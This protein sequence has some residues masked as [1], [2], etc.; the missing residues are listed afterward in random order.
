MQCDTE[1]VTHLEEAFSKPSDGEQVSVDRDLFHL[2]ALQVVDPLEFKEVK[3]LAVEIL[4][5]LPPPSVT[6]FVFAQLLTFLREEAPMLAATSFT[7]SLYE[8][9]LQ[10]LQLPG[11][12]GIIT[13]KLMVYYLNRVI[14]EDLG[15]FKDKSQ[16]PFIV[17]V[18][19]QVLS[20]PSN[21]MIGGDKSERNLLADLQMG[22]MDCVALLILRKLGD[23]TVE[24]SKKTQTTGSLL[25]VL[26]D[27]IIFDNVVSQIDDDEEV[28]KKSSELTFAVEMM[29]LSLVSNAPQ[30]NGDLS[31]PLQVRICGC[32]ILLRYAHARYE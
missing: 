3:M 7:E 14:N 15:V 22:C 31:L 20:I 18:L 11:Y 17:A 10:S 2:L 23:P 8:P 5:K 29:L 21:G 16:V 24:A 12:C 26:M 19:L 27:W 1:D 30:H 4:A 25:D 6:P 9:A 28:P 32:N 13:A